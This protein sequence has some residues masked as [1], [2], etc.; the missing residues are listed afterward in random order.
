MKNPMRL[1]DREVA[2]FN[3]SKGFRKILLIFGRLAAAF[4]DALCCFFD[5]LGVFRVPLRPRPEALKPKAD[6]ILRA[7]EQGV[8]DTG[9]DQELINSFRSLPGLK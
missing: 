4:G 1:C 9:V 6:G 2:F 5:V 7:T 3:Q 8:L